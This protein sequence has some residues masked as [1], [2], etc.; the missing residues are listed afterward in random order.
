MESFEC[1]AGRQITSKVDVGDVDRPQNASIAM[2][3]NSLVLILV[4]AYIP[5]NLLLQKQ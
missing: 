3:H 5:T 4:Y 1:S 2:L